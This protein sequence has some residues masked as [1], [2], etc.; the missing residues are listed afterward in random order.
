MRSKLSPVL[1]AALLAA[2]CSPAPAEIS[3]ENCD[4]VATAALFG[5]ESRA[6]GVPEAEFYRRIDTLGL[7]QFEDMTIAALMPYE[8]T[9]PEFH[10]LSMPEQRELVFKLCVRGAFEPYAKY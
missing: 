4:A 8:V 7:T 9:A 3:V 5:A 2:Q 10:A 1:L 6:K